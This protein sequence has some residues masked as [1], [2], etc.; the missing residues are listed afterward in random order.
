MTGRFALV[1]LFVISFG[2]VGGVSLSESAGAAALSGGSWRADLRFLARE[3]PA[4]H[5]NAFHT[6]SRDDFNRAVA[7][8]D[9]RIPSLAD[10]EVIIE[11]QRV[12]ALIGDGHTRLD[13]E[14]PSLGFKLLP[15][16]VYRF[17]E[18]WYVT[19]AVKK[20][21]RMVGARLLRVGDLD[22]EDAYARAR[23]VISHDNEMGVKTTAPILLVSAK[24]L[25]A[26]GLG[27]NPKLARYQ[28]RDENGEP[29]EARVKVLKSEADQEWILARGSNG[30]NTPLYLR[31]PGENYWYAY[32]ENS[33]TLFLQYDACLNKPDKP[34]AQFC[35]EVFAFADS[36]QVERF[37]VDV[38][39]N[40]GGDFNVNRPLIEELRTRPEI[41]RRG[42]LFTIIGR[43]TASAAMM[44]V[45]D[46]IRNFG[47]ILVGEPTGANTN[48]YG[49]QESFVLP[50]SRVRVL[51]AT[52]FHQLTEPRDELRPFYPDITAEPSFELYRANRDPAWE[53]VLNYPAA[54][55]TIT[56]TSRY[57][58]EG[59]VQS[60]SVGVELV[61]KKLTAPVA[62]VSSADGTGRLFIVDQI[63]QVRILTRDRTLKKSPFLDL[64]D[65][66]LPLRQ[67][68]D[69]RGFLG[70]AF[71]PAFRQNGRFFVYYSAPLR[72]E[73][74]PGGDHTNHLSEFRVSRNDPNRAD[75]SSER[76]MLQLDYVAPNIFHQGGQLAFG[77][78]GY[79]YVGLGDGDDRR[80][81][82]DIETLLGKI[83]RIDVDGGDPYGIPPDNPFV[84]RPGRDEIF[85]YGLRNP[86]RFSFDAQGDHELLVADV[87]EEISEEVDIITKGGNYGWSI[88]EGTTCFNPADAEHP[89]PSCPSIG[90]LGEPL[91]DPVIEYDHTVGRAIIGGFVY[92]GTAL[93]EFAGRYIFGN[94]AT[95]T[96]PPPDGKLFVANSTPSGAW[97]IQELRIA[98]GSDGTLGRVFVFAL[99]QDDDGELY[100]LTSKNVGPVGKTGRVMKIVPAQ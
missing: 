47:S 23:P 74:P 37:V 76:V 93:P 34:F 5:V 61:A 3:L 4:R 77:P 99:G 89:L 73:G 66:M 84:G 50:N 10:H 92:R 12:V 64:R 17:S 91:I 24:T 41:T 90:G 33:K 45:S 83:L 48:H 19:A 14:E 18:G 54:S 79:L 78:D 80:N 29:F 11:L 27:D 65:R 53:A 100:V 71:H 86:Y 72:R 82:Q 43:R 1:A 21:A 40:M 88:R 28:A 30:P 25:H 2:S 67:D 7:S 9:A 6:V 95:R 8:L 94:W 13:L 31:N 39:Q 62:F 59:E 42:K 56:S 52:V 97:E 57:S 38:R 69:E 70:L 60:P 55:T 81:G 15:L 46:L 36:H 85:A 58:S 26:L 16:R 96:M 44:C 87:G 75:L 68:Y 51:Y 35:R 22:I 20:Y 49:D 32:E 63:G 98:T